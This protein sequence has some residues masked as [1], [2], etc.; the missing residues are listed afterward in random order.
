[1]TLDVSWIGHLSA[2]TGLQNL[3]MSGCDGIAGVGITGL[4]TRD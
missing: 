3:Y 2:L 1:M 4:E